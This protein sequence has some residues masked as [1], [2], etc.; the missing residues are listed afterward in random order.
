M[1]RFGRFSLRRRLEQPS[2]PPAALPPAAHQLRQPLQRTASYLPFADAA[3][4]AALL[5]NA[6]LAGDSCN[7]GALLGALLGAALGAPAIPRDLLEGLQRGPE[8]RTTA[9]ALAACAVAPL[10]L[11]RAQE[12]RIPCRFGRPWPVPRVRFD[13]LPSL[14]AQEGRCETGG[15]AADAVTGFFAPVDCA[16]KL[17]AISTICATLPSPPIT[18]PAHTHQPTVLRFLRGT[19]AV[20]L[21]TSPGA[22]ARVVPLALPAGVLP[23]LLSPGFPAN[24]SH[25][26]EPWVAR[27]LALRQALC[28]SVAETS[29]ASAA[30]SERARDALTE[31]VGAG[32]LQLD[33]GDAATDRALVM[34]AQAKSAESAV[35][36]SQSASLAGLRV[37]VDS[38]YINTE[39]A[40]NISLD[41]VVG[42]S[43][44]ARAAG[45][46]SPSAPDTTAL[47][48][49]LGVASAPG[50]GA[51]VF[52]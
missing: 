1:A 39:S 43:A 27:I 42:A 33:E 37:R 14:L 22:L 13:A 25:A 19:G 28:V 36:A 23:T 24:A 38:A 26:E 2:P 30:T 31:R 45:V 44:G 47:A 12:A 3:L 10:A 51:F 34:Q 35:Y 6:N 9:A 50:C 17:R 5:S 41:S 7:R 52:L 46:F 11:D 18:S 49:L 40:T 21:I 29:W 15:S 4:R 48:Q 32:A 20:S 8:L 16:H